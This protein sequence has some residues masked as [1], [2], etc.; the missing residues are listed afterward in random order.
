[1]PEEIIN[2][3]KPNILLVDDEKDFAQAMSTL[4]S[5]EGFQVSLA[6]SGTEALSVFDR[7]QFDLIVTDLKMPIMDGIELVRQ[8]RK[9]NPNQPIVIV[10]GF[11]GQLTPWNRR[12]NETEEDVLELGSLSYL[13]KP[14]QPKRLIE[15]VKSAIEKNKTRPRKTIQEVQIRNLKAEKGGVNWVSKIAQ[16]TLEE[17]AESIDGL[18]A[19]GL[20]D[21]SGRT[22]AQV[23]PAGIAP[24]HYCGRFAIIM[25]IMREIARETGSARIIQTLVESESYWNLAHFIGTSNYYLCIVAARKAPLGNLR[26]VIRKLAERFEKIVT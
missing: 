24:E 16:K 2:Q 6:H 12:L 1:M 20:A 25:S 3:I 17:N 14:F 21:T 10:T 11:P 22:L 7:N 19:V 8:V 23:N 15:V 13:V 9:L 18:M 5:A 4:L 26:T